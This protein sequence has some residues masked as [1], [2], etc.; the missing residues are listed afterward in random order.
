[1]RK[2]LFLF[3]LLWSLTLVVNA[4]EVV[5]PADL[6]TQLRFAASQ[7]SGKIYESPY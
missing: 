5:Q 2:A 6:E 4:Q 7:L 1:M 3:T